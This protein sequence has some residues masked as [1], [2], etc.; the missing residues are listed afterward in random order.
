MLRTIRWLFYGMLVLSLPMG[1]SAVAKRPSA[2]VTGSASYRERIALSPG[3]VFEATLQ[4]VSRADAPPRVV[5]RYRRRDPGQVPISFDLPY[6]RGRIDPRGRYVVRATIHDRGQLRFT[7]TR[8][9]PVI[10]HG[11][12][13][14]VRLLLVHVATPGDGPRPTGG[15]EEFFRELNATRRYR[16]RE[17][18]LEL[19]DDRGNRI[20]LLEEANLR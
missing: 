3:A 10:T 11:H 13:N 16:V 18:T 6:R 12:G 8:G 4:D 5:A 14:R 15:I 19:F 17:R 1:S 7:T 20:L 2:A 9:Y